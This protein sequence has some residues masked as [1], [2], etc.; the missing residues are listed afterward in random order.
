MK[1]ACPDCGKPFVFDEARFGERESVKVRCP[2]CKG[3]VP[4]ARPAPAAAA[5]PPAPP[6][7]GA[8]EK[9]SGGG[10]PTQKLK[11]DQVVA[12]LDGGE[13]LLP[14]PRGL[15]VSLAILT[16]RGAGQVVV[17]QKARVILGRAGADVQVDD[18]EVSRQHACL[19]IRDERFVL[20]DLGSTNG[21]FVDERKITESEIG[22]RGEFRIGST[23]IMLIVTPD[24]EV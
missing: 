7:R 14:M 13:R 5:E 22:D 6:A 21:T 18:D 10:A 23:Q 16:G 3:V 15:R 11:R 4:L 17:C 19:E 9:G 20:K 8:E 24:E 1:A 2:S 12:G